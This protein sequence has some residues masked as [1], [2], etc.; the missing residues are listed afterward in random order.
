MTFPTTA[1]TGIYNTATI[2]PSALA[3]SNG[4]KG[5]ADALAG[6][7]QGDGINGAFGLAHA[8][9]NVGAF[10]AGVLLIAR[11]HTRW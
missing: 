2:D 8:L 11:M 7:N 5:I 9:P 10:I 6:T 1:W 3:A 4:N